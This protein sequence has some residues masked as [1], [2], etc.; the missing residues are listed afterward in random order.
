MPS[1]C[2]FFRGLAITHTWE[3]IEDSGLQDRITFRAGDYFRDDF[4]RGNDV[5]LLSEVLHLM[6]SR[7][8]RLLLKKSFDP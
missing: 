5:V 4:G 6:G 1:Q 8:C 2:H 7:Q 3:V